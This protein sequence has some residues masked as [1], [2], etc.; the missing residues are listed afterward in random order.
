LLLLFI[1]LKKKYRGWRWW[2]MPIISALG[3]L[4]KE[5]CE[6]EVSLGYAVRP[7]LEEGEAKI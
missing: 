3:R 5:D 6:F 4:R 7:C 2:Y 1:E